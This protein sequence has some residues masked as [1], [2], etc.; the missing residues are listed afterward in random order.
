MAIIHDKNDNLQ[1]YFR[2]FSDIRPFTQEKTAYLN[3]IR[4]AAIINGN[5]HNY[6]GEL[7]NVCITEVAK[8]FGVKKD[9]EAL[10]FE[11]DIINAFN[12]SKNT[13][14]AVCTQEL[15][16]FS[17]KITSIK[18]HGGFYETS[19]DTGVVKNNLWSVGNRQ[20]TRVYRAVAEAVFL[21]QTEEVQRNYVPVGF[22]CS[23]PY[24]AIALDL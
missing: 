1:T 19:E 21:N 22:Y 8:Y 15:R 5:G 2:S 7:W 4:K 17:S 16:R 12:N 9:A 10:H 24:H 20:R 23:V 11:S 6:D 3:R 13:F 18:Y 14:A